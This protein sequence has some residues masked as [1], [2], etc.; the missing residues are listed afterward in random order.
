[1]YSEPIINI[2]IIFSNIDKK[3]TELEIILQIILVL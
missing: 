3:T 2:K 1:M